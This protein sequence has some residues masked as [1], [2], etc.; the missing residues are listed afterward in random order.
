MTKRI[1]RIDSYFSL[2]TDL[3]TALSAFPEFVSGEGYCAELHSPDE[4][5]SVSY[6]PAHDDDA[7]HVLVAGTGEGLLFFAVLGCTVHA[8]S[9]HS[10]NVSVLRWTHHET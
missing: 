4:E 7:A 5:V 10:D 3:A 1:A 2:P 8:L 6:H 9:A